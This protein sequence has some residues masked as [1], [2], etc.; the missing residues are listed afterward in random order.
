M[1]NQERANTA[2]ELALTESDK[3]IRGVLDKM[4]IP[5]ILHFRDHMHRLHERQIKM[6]EDVLKEKG[7][8]ESNQGL[9]G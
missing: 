6:V 5:A 7:Y 1:E 8:V 2:V 3:A 9:S 4:P